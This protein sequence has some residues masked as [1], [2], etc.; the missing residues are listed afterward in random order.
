MHRTRIK[1]CGVTRVEDALAAARHGADAI[2]IVMQRNSKRFV[3]PALARQIVSALPAFVTPVALFFDAPPSEVIQTARELGARHV[4]L[5]G[6]ELPDE[7]AAVAPLA[8]IKAVRVTRMGLTDE[9]ARWRGAPA[10]LIGMVLETATAKG[11]GGTGVANDWEFIE[12]SMKSGEFTGLPHIIAAGGLTPESVGDVVRR[13][14][15]WAVDVSSGVE[16]SL[17]MKSESKLQA[18]CGAVRDADLTSSASSDRSAP[19]ASG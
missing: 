11:G 7:V 8:V 15:P 17:G 2:G 13:I 5:H 14:R 12:S 1:I 4:Q 10:N 19:P 18:F 6:H 3:E 9:L 16:S